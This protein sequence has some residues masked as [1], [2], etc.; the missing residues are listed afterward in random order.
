MTK[1]PELLNGVIAGAVLLFF[2]LAGA[3]AAG[4]KSLVCVDWLADNLDR[5]DLV[6]LDVSEFTN[7]QRGHIPGAVK[8]FGPWQTMND[9]FLGFMIPSPDKLVKMLREFG[10]NNN[11][12]VVVYDEGTT[13]REISKSARALWT[14][15]SL[16]HEDVAL[17]DGG[18]S[19]WKREGRQ[20]SRKPV[21]AEIGNFSGNLIPGKVTTLSGVKKKLD[22]DQ[23][24]FLDC[25]SAPEHFGQEKKSHI[26]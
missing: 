16:G 14:L 8:A 12:F 22:N 24:V 4:T 23:V 17:L 3:S 2:S 20:V 25:R 10:I 19:A 6:I 5:R 7:Y 15:H 18:F 13:A 11:S 9:D 21:A 1:R 26:D